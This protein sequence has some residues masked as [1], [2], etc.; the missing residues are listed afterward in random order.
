MVVVKYR[1]VPSLPRS[2]ERLRRFLADISKKLFARRVLMSFFLNQTMTLTLNMSCPMY[3]AEEVLFFRDRR[4]DDSSRIR[5]ARI[6][7]VVVRI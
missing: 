2:F 1:I 5:I 7:A 4:G 3:L 6:H